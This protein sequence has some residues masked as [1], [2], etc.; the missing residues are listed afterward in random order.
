M[1]I[2]S[3]AAAVGTT[4]FEGLRGVRWVFTAEGFVLNL[5]SRIANLAEAG[6]IFVCPE[7]ARRLAGCFPIHPVGRHRLKNIAEAIEVAEL[8]RPGMTA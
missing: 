6:Q 4:R 3:G 2:S 1:G 5:G 7:S 8:R